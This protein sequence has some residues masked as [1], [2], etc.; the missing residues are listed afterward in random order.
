LPNPGTEQVAPFEF[1]TEHGSG[2]FDAGAA[3]KIS[4]PSAGR[5]SGWSS[6]ISALAIRFFFEEA[7]VKS[8]RNPLRSA[9][10]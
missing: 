6:R 5:Q 4:G 1:F 2:H 10:L 3:G 9:P 7:L 8:A